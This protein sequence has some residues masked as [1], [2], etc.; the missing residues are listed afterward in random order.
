M[1]TSARL[2]GQNVLDKLDS[3]SQQG[4]QN[5]IILPCMHFHLKSI[6]ISFI[7]KVTTVDK[8]MKV[9]NDRSLCGTILVLFLEFRSGHQIEISHMNR[10]QNLSR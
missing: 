5:G 3:L 7:S 2:Q 4:G 1:N 8:A 6:Q 10:R 9:A